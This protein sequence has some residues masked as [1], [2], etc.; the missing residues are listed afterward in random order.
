MKYRI[1]FF[2]LML[3]SSFSHG[4]IKLEIPAIFGDNMVLQRNSRAELCGDALPDAKIE[5]AASW[6][7]QLTAEAGSD[8]KWNIG[9]PT[10]DAGGPYE[11]KII[12]G[13]EIFTL[14]E[15]LIGEV[16]LCSGQSNME[17]P[18]KGW[19]PNDPILNSDDEIAKA[20]F[21][22]IRLFTVQRK[23]SAEKL[24]DVTGAWNSCTPETAS[25]FS[26]TAYFF[27]RK[28]YEELQIP[29]GL[30]H[31]SWGGTPAEA[32]TDVKFLKDVPGFQ[33][34]AEQLEEM[35][36]RQNEFKTWLDGHPTV[37]IEDINS[38]TEFVDIDF[39][40]AA[41]SAGKANE[42]WGEI[43]LPVTWESTEVGNFDGAVWFAKSV[44]IPAEW[45]GRELVLELGP[46]DDMDATYV[47][48]KKVGGYET[49]GHWQTVRKYKVSSEILLEGE[50]KIAV[51]VI[52][53]QGGGGIYGKE[54]SM[55]IYPADE[56]N[57][58]ISLAGIWKYYPV[59]EYTGGKF[60]LYSKSENEL[61]FR[62]GFIVSVN[63]NS[64]TMLYNAMIHP[65]SGY[66]IRGAIWYQGESN[67]GRAAQ[68]EK[69]FPAMIQSWR[70]AWGYDFPF[71]FTQIAPYRYGDDA[72]SQELRDAQRKSLAV[73]KTGMAVTLDIGN[74]ENI[75]P[76]NKQDVGKR[77]AL[78][79]LKNDYGK[80]VL[81]S[82]P[83]Y[84]TMKINGDKISLE[85]DYTGEGLVLKEAEKSEFLIAGEDRIF[86]PAEAV[87]A[88]DK[89]VV[90][91]E[92]I[93]NP[94][95]V[96]YSWSNTS[97]AQLFNK[98]GLPA[99]TFRT[100]NW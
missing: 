39:G 26:A 63:A 56:I 22:E 89:V 10:P 8:G 96:R 5:I 68:Y 66:T 55:K 28:L 1:W 57:S 64:P 29:I 38:P 43:E 78:W 14:K 17:M 82:G 80:S 74:V 86:H 95:S 91:S 42:N 35:I 12:S 20:D 16:W 97:G 83:L 58:A 54:S 67:T 47:N 53:T 9:I 19:P 61:K 72:N 71:Y 15:I 52:D 98:E 81:P 45:D 4:Q 37:K 87:I 60:Y 94:K 84:K 11:L 59:A 27:G 69:L 50:N 34:F 13:R 24:D 46:I 21:P 93:K 85:F 41:F 30:I 51:R 31:S 33:D 99:S 73:P 49:G 23:V 32:W 62:P 75:H 70:S 90:W 79:A 92:E 36:P 2:T 48:G 88:R 40:D 3:I 100:D 44:D 25:S 77:L 18:L 76:A 6:G 7:E 65:I